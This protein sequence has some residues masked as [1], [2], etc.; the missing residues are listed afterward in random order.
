MCALTNQCINSSD[1]IVSAA[2][3]QRSPGTSS[4]MCWKSSKKFSSGTVGKQN[5]CKKV[6][7]LALKLKVEISKDSPAAGSTRNLIKEI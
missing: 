5:N 3:C 2:K 1:R 4:L 7:A 6:E